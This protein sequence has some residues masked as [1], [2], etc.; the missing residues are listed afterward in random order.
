MFTNGERAHLIKNWY[1]TKDETYSDH[2]LLRFHIE[3]PKLETRKRWKMNAIQK[4]SLTRETRALAH[5]LLSNEQKRNIDVSSIEALS[6]RLMQGLIQ[7][8]KSY[9]TEYTIKIR[10]RINLWFDK[11]LSLE[12]RTLWIAKHAYANAKY[13]SAKRT[14]S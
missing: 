11:E 6:T 3:A 12:R 5:D 2:K 7:A 4:E 10:D 13:D 9:S 1:V 8:H 14:K